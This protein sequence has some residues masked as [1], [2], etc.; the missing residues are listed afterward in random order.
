MPRVQGSPKVKEQKEVQRPGISIPHNDR[1]RDLSS[2]S[3]PLFHKWKSLGET[4]IP[5]G[6]K[7][8][9]GSAKRKYQSKKEN[10]TPENWM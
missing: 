8:E 7:V 10:I 9:E 4:E 3:L 5:P 2:L 6:T 1:E